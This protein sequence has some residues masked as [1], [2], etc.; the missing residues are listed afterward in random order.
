MANHPGTPGKSPHPAAWEGLELPNLTTR[1]FLTGNGARMGWNDL[2][3]FARNGTEAMGR[4]QRGNGAR[5][6]VSS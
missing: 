5:T 1:K 6:G 4:P 2:V 3:P